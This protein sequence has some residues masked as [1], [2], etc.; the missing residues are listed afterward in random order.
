MAHRGASAT[1]PEN[2]LASFDA[3]VA[4]GADAI[5]LD[6]RLTQD[7]APVIMHD[8]SVER[9]TDGAGLVCE[10]TLAEIRKIRATGEPVPTLEEAIAS[11]SG[12]A[13][14][15]IEIKNIPGEPDFEPGGRR[16]VE[17][18]LRSLAGSSF[19]GGV[20]LSC[21]DP[22]TLRTVKQLRPDLPRGLLSAVDVEAT[23]ALRFASSEG[24]SWL[25]SHVDRV[26]EAGEG[27]IV[28]ARESGLRVGAWIVD[29]PARVLSLFEMGVDAVATN[30]PARIVSELGRRTG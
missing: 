26:E 6:V 21:F 17:A 5:E 24:C 18:V 12:R 25:L 2:T 10:K 29:E 13:G 19:S 27:L 20:L 7:G 8:P 3:A 23:G 30:D 16:V 11:I 14:L 28:A 22:F 9:T 4:V 15:D 1:H